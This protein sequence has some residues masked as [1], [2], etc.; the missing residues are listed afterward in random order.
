M[1]IVAAAIVTYNPNIE[2]LGQVIG[3]I[4]NQVEKI[5]IVDN[6]S[7]NIELIKSLFTRMLYKLHFVFNTENKGLAT[8]LNQ[9]FE[10]AQNI[11]CQWVLTLDQ[12]SLCSKDI[13]R[14]YNRYV[15]SANIGIISCKAVFNRPCTEQ[16]S[17]ED[18]S[19]KD[20]DHCITGGSLISVNA[21]KSVGGFDD[22]LFIEW[23]DFVFCKDIKLASYRILQL[24]FEGV[25]QIGGTCKTKKIFN[26]TYVY[27]SYSEIRRYY[28]MRNL[29]YYYRKFKYNDINK[30]WLLRWVWT[31][32]KGIILFEDNKLKKLM[33]VIRAM[34]D[35]QK[36]KIS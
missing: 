33:I 16:K 9:V 17:F 27:S 29:I 34:L 36:M 15:N 28:Q 11:G 22:I 21:W 6:G 18:I 26:K 30:I 35:G 31:Y 7:K 32:I 25:S 23:I 13:I 24:D 19:A 10:E 2:R 3:S 12:D 4:E 14:I 5:I 8:A 1:G 20:I